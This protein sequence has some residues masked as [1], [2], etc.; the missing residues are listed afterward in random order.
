[1]QSSTN[2]DLVPLPPLPPSTPPSRLRSP[3]LRKPV[4]QIQEGFDN[5]SQ[6]MRIEDVG[7]ERA[8]VTSSQAQP[9]AQTPPRT[10]VGI[11]RRDIPV[12]FERQLSSASGSDAVSITSVR[13]TSTF[14]R[15]SSTR[16]LPPPPPQENNNNMISQLRR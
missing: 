9:R 16:P 15:P 13:T 4:P 5:G 3:V 2:W 12:A 10:M 11:G 6:L 8:V 14:S 7:R 1:M